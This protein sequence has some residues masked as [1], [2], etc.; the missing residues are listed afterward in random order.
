MYSLCDGMIIIFNL[1]P[2]KQLNS[3]VMN[4]L[5]HLPTMYLAIDLQS[6]VLSTFV[7]FS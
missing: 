5:R 7:L 4:V 6:I 2:I 1:R 3:V